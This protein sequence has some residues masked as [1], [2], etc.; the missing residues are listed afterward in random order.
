MFRLCFWEG[1][2]IQPYCISYFFV[3]ERPTIVH[4]WAITHPI[5][6]DGDVTIVKHHS[7]VDV[8]PSPN[9][10]QHPLNGETT[11]IHVLPPPD[12]ESASP[13]TTTSP[14]PVF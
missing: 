2:D 1:R 8:D 11:E 7:T 10:H 6:T 5:F 12:H 14:H 4:C 9:G 13:P 3:T